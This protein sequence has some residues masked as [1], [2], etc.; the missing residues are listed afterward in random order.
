MKPSARLKITAIALAGVLWVQPAYALT[1]FDPTNLAQ[2]VKTA[3]NTLEQ[4]HNQIQQIE[5]QARMLTKNPLQL[6]GEL[7]GAINQARSLF[8]AAQGLA[9]QVDQISDD[10]KTLYPD[11]FENFDLASIGQRTDRWLTEDRAAL[12]RAVR[13]QAQAVQA[14]ET[15][16][17]RV[18]RALL[19]SASSEGQTGAVQAGNQLLG[20]N[21][22]ELMQIHALLVTES[23]ALATE[24]L[25]RV[26]RE[27][28]AQEIQRRAFPT[29][30][31]GVLAPARSAFGS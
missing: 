18:D 8:Q 6:S 7:N 27:Q 29:T 3:A 1:V 10:L 4:I 21:A 5:Q 2:N 26:A 9:F 19:A 11:T 23:R 22:A 13:A 28:R 12:E 16:Q 15:M 30:T 17:G 14:I 24:R 25:E 31:S 20:V